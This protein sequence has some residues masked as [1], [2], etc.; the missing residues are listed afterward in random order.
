[1]HQIAEH[2]PHLGAAEQRLAEFVRANP[3]NVAFVSARTLATQAGVSPATVVRFFPRVGFASYAD[4]Q[5][6]LQAALAV[7]YEAPQQR[8]QADSAVPA[9]QSA[10]IKTV[11]QDIRNLQAM[12]QL[13]QSPAY[14]QLLTWLSTCNGRVAVVG[15]R[16]SRGPAQL[17]AH[18]LSI[19]LATDWVDPLQGVIDSLQDYGNQDIALCISVR[20][21]LRH[22]QSLARWLREQGVRVVALTDDAMSPLALHSDLVLTLPTQ[23]TA[24][25]DSYSAFTG[26]GN[27]LISEL[28]LSRRSEVARRA[29]AREQVD[30]QLGFYPD[31]PLA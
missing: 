12:A 22:T 29:S 5:Q 23:G 18:Q 9:Q 16:Y 19:A 2:L 17:L 11:E 4:A 25:F 6:Q 21:Y 20:R 10:S 13:V 14:A 27:A 24:V 31:K 15:G 26:L 7:Q 30:Q 8:L 1:M 3:H 28:C